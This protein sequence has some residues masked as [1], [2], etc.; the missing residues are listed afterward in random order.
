M[1]APARSGWLFKDIG[2]AGA[3]AEL[4]RPEGI[5]LTP[6]GRVAL[7]S[8]DD[9]IRQSILLLLTTIPGERVMRPDYG[10]PLHRL[11]FAPNDATTA[12]LAIHYVR[13]ALVRFEPRVDIVSLDAQAADDE[14][15]KLIIS[16]EYR[17]RSTNR[18]ASLDLELGLYG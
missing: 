5:A 8:G 14:A 9:A 16:L 7:V 12:G 6:A 18:Q 10:C 15:S 1:T 13:Q 17:V 3:A 11:L 2:L 4:A